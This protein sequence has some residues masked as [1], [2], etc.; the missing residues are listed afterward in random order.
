MLHTSA[1]RIATRLWLALTVAIILVLSATVALRVHEEQRLLLEITL[2]DRLFYAHALQQ[3]LV[4]GGAHNDPLNE[5]RRLLEHESIDAGHIEA[6][7][8][9]LTNPSL[10][11]PELDDE[12]VRRLTAHDVAVNIVDDEIITFVP[13]GSDDVII[14]LA[15]PHAVNELLVRL[16]LRSLLRQT[17]LLVVLVALLMY[18]LVRWLVGTPLSRLAQVARK[19]GAGD[20]SVRA[21][22]DGSDEVGILSREMNLMI[23]EPQRGHKALE[24]ADFE[25]TSLLE[26]LRHADRLRT[27]GELAS[28]LAHELGTPLNVVS[29]HARLLEEEV[30]D[31]G[32]DSVQEILEQSTRMTRVLRNLLDFSRRDRQVGVHNVLWLVTKAVDTLKILANRRNVAIQILADRDGGPRVRADAQ[33]ILQVLTN[34]VINAIQAIPTRG[35]VSIG[36]R[37]QDAVPPE[38]VRATRGTY[39]IITITDT[40]TGIAPEDI[41]RLFEPYFTRKAPGVGTGLG[42]PVVEGIVREHGG[43]VSVVSEVGKGTTFEVML[44]A[45]QS[46]TPQ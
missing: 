4:Q 39:A 11:H 46:E 5:A 40:G 29:G 8:V 3:A 16:G 34:L 27:V 6:R 20:L 23:E 43:W 26:R 13:V 21:T 25:R 24:E 15:E 18:V 36:W 33:Q 45:Y 37:Q 19:V 35:T 17:A 22:S 42:L 30:S 28:A 9:S 14:E 44:P 2:R 1:V 41:P 12:S 31:E 38:G 10:P 32:R 7:L